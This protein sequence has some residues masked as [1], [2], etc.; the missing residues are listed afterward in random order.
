MTQ[1]RET[2]LALIPARAGSKG[3]PDKNLRMLGGISLTAR[4][5]RCAR[6]A[7]L[8]DRIVVTTDGEQIA[9]VASEEGAEVIYRPSELASDTA[10]IVDV[11]EHALTVLAKEHYVPAVVALLE[12]SSPLRTAAMIKTAIEALD[13]CDALFT[14]SEVP[15]GFHPAKQFLLDEKGRAI[16]VSP[17]LPTPVRRQELTPTYIRNGAV[18][19]FRASMFFLHHSV[20]GPSPKALVLTA[21]LVNIDT[22]DDLAEAERLIGSGSETGARLFN[23]A[24][25]S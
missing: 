15:P 4:A 18:Y 6:E 7:E 24:K 22:L 16:S 12:P 2:A 9:E 3:V 10:N 8:F 17:D 21:P 5:V 20:L 1:K 25:P 11:I 14:V 13:D 19:V 23:Q